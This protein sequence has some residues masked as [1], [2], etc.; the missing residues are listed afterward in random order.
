ML[1]RN[2][3]KHGVT[4]VEIL[5][6]FC[7]LS[8]LVYFVYRLF[9]AYSRTQEIG[10]WSTATIKELRNGLTLLRNEISRATKPEVVTQKGTIPFDTGNGDREKFLYCPE[11][12]PYENDFTT[13][14]T[15]ILHFFMCRP[16]KKDL[17]GEA[18]VSPEVLSGK[19]IIKNKKLVYQRT[20]D[21]QPE[22]IP[23]KIPELTQVIANSPSRISLTLK[24]VADPAE[25]SVSNRNFIVISIEAQHPRY[26][27][28]KVVETA[29]IP[30]EVPV[31]KGGFP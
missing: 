11:T 18:D 17:P 28:S 29:E 3:K 10:H 21:S 30:F 7:I 9:S 22:G 14:D 31:K 19:L 20:I 2:L 5:I 27:N 15:T 25:L 13:G 1:K 6:A 16:G 12:M 8:M 24:E 4:L 23:D 26:S